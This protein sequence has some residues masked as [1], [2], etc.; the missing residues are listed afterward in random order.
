MD[1][2]LL[3]DQPDQSVLL[4]DFAEED[5]HR[6]HRAVLGAVDLDQRVG[7]VEAVW[8]AGNCSL[9]QLQQDGSLER[10]SRFMKEQVAGRGIGYLGQGV[11]LGLLIEALGGQFDPTEESDLLFQRIQL[12]EE[13]ATGVLMDGIPE[14][15]DAPVCRAGQ[16]VRMPEHAVCL[17][18]SEEIP[19]QAVRWEL[20][21]YATQFL[22]ETAL[23]KG[24][25]AIGSDGFSATAYEAICERIYIN[26]LQ[27]M[28]R[29]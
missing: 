11:G 2:L 15:F 12:T 20:R 21:A 5:G 19:V 23:S 25:L 7:D 29:T 4:A 27:M 22:L 18:T 6:V 9:T 28:A 26:W 13:G 16:T 3:T 1:I 14:L 10:L 24:N 8:L 17:A